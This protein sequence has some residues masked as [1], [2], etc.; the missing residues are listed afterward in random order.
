MEHLQSP[1]IDSIHLPLLQQH[2]DAYGR[3]ILAHFR[4]EEA[5]E[6]V[7]REDGLFTCAAS[8]ESY[9]APFEAWPEYERQAIALARGRVLDIGCGAGRVALHLQNLGLEVLGVD[10]SPLALEVCRMRGVKQV[11]LASIT[12]LGARLGT[13]DTLALYGNNFGL[14]GSLEE[15]R[16]LLRRFHTFTSPG[17][18]I[19]AESNDLS[20]TRDPIHL[21]YQDRNRSRGRLPGQ[22]RIRVRYLT[23]ATPWFDYLIVSKPEMESILEGTGWHVERYFDAAPDSPQA[24][25]YVAVLRKTGADR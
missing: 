23:Y 9:F 1:E 25:M 24:S 3:E 19:L 17:A 8:P 7:E 12:E 4:S 5:F 18:R 2:E 6:I 11:Q 16:R 14:T 10:N 21:A 13:F 15:A 22:L 20:Q